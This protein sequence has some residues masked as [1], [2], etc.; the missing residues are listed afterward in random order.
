MGQQLDGRG[1]GRIGP[2]RLFDLAQ[3]TMSWRGAFFGGAAL[4]PE[5]GPPDAPVIVVDP[6]RELPGSN[7][8]DGEQQQAVQRERSR[9][10][11]RARRTG[12]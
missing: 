12:T 11:M 4:L 3:A 2:W 7:I 1:R 5:H 9:R 8:G 10:F 6:A